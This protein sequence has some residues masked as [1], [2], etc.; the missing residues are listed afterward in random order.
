MLQR[1]DAGEE[2][3]NL[4]DVVLSWRLT[5]VMNEDLFKDKVKKIPSTFPHL[6]SYLERYTSPLLEE[7]RAEMSSSLES[8][9]TV[10]SVRI[11]RIEEKKDGYEISV[12][13]DCQVAKPCNHPECMLSVGDIIVLSDVKPGHISDITRN[14]RPYRV[15][16]VTDGGDEDD[17][18]PPAKYAIIASG[19]I[20]AAD[21]GCQDGKSASLFAACLL[22]IVTYIRIWRCLDY[23]AAVRRN[24][25]LI[26]KMPEQCF[27]LF[28]QRNE[29]GQYQPVPDTCQK[30]T[31]DA[32]SIDSVEIW[33]K[34]STMDLNTSQNDAVLNSISKMHCKSN[35][36]TL[37]WGP[38]GTGKTKTIS[39]LLWL[40]REMKRGTLVLGRC[41][42]DW[43]QTA[44]VR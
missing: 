44:H 38:P 37:I 35:T 12:A 43:Q 22:N 13:S 2:W 11:S 27:D 41:S 26:Q 40:M 42:N 9:S 10:P 3:P 24:Q 34:L 18:S 23:E 4:V 5:D 33:T 19:K 25:G 29:Q 28:F 14:G 6:R 32:G 36:F 21:G 16:F 1:K 31:E 17:D 20:D 39:V 15:A 30:S 7:L 8:L